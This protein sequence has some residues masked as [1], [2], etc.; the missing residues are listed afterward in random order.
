[1][2]PNKGTCMAED[3]APKTI[4]VHAR[5]AE[6]GPAS[7]GKCCT[8]AKDALGPIIPMAKFEAQI[9]PTISISPHS[10]IIP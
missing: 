9:S 1:M 7:R 4:C 5:T 6:A 8:A 2:I 3:A 10:V